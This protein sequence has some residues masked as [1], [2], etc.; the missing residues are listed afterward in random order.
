[1][2]RYRIH[3]MKESPRE[4]FRW[5]P[6]TGGLAIVKTKDYDL[7]GEIEASTPYAVWKCLLGKGRPLRPGDLLETSHVDGTSGQLHIAKYIGFEP[8]SWYVPEPRPAVD[9]SSAELAEA[10]GMPVQSDPV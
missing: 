7:D 10:T 2:P 5:A 8:A 3:R 9:A 1:M 6:H 4:S